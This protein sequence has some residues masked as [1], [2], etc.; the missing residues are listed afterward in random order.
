MAGTAVFVDANT[1]V[2]RSS[3]H[4]QFGPPCVALLDRIEGGELAGYTSSLAISEMAHRLMTLEAITLFRWPAANIGNRLRGNPSEV[5]KLTAFRQAIDRLLQSKLQV[6]DH[7]SAL[8]ATDAATCQQVGLLT[9]D[10]LVVVVM[11]ANGLTN[12][13]SAD[14]DFDRGA[15][16]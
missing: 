9:N 13:A 4:P 6:A 8:L 14:A 11:Q 12:I 2:Y 5:A 10:G 1:L 15:R 3:L 7:H 16:P